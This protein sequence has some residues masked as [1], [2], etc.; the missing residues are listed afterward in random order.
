M[1]KIALLALLSAASFYASAQRVKLDIANT[2]ATTVTYLYGD[3]FDNRIEGKTKYQI[4]AD[5]H[6]T[7]DITFNFKQPTRASLVLSPDGGYGKQTFFYRLYLSPGDDIMLSA[8]FKANGN[9]LTVTGKGSENNQPLLAFRPLV[10]SSEQRFLGDSVPDRVIAVINKEQL[11][12]K[13]ALN[14]YLKKYNP[15]APFVKAQKYDVEY[16]ALTTYFGFKENNKGR[17]KQPYA[18]NVAK[19]QRVQDS[20]LDAISRDLALPARVSANKPAPADKSD[21]LLKHIPGRK[22]S[23]INNPDALGTSN[24]NSLIREFV[25]RYR[26]YLSEQA[27]YRPKDIIAAWYG[28][29]SVAAKQA[30]NDDSNNVLREKIINKFFSG[31]VEEYLLANLIADIKAKANPKNVV[32]IYNRFKKRF[33]QSQYVAP[34]RSYIDSVIENQ[35]YQLT[36]KMVFAPGNGNKLNTLDEILALSKGKTVFVDMWG[37][38]CA[39][40]RENLAQHGPAI[41]EHFKNKGLNYLYIANRDERNQKDWKSLI[42]YF[43]LEGTHV[44]ANPQLSQ[45]IMTKLKRSTYPTYFIIKKDGTYEL[46]DGDSRLDR[47][48]LFKQ[49][50]AALAME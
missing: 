18:R 26:E 48:K 45:D 2:T 11:E 15:S 7:A 41:K 1:K 35:K 39:P 8:D 30:Y 9:G 40:C 44:L 23:V 32:S 49:I 20:L 50:E 47:D 37:S 25:G 21:I 27:F 16:E 19:W 29:D 46:Y 5:Q 3:A 42:A 17:G 33:P 24:Y 13:A 22:Y 38:W 10:V 34:Y 43:K 12:S 31:T 14:E 6:R 4:S 28:A 36:D